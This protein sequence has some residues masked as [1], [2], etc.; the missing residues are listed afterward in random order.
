LFGY[1]AAEL[2]GRPVTIL[3]PE[4]H[5]ARYADSGAM[6]REAG[7]AV[8]QTV[9]LIGRRR[10]GSD[11]PLEI[12][13][14]SWQADGRVSFTGV[15]RDVS[16]RRRHADELRE[17]RER[18]A[19]AFDHA[20]IGMA[21]VAPD[22][23]WL[24]VNESLCGILGYSREEL[25]GRTFQDITHPDD[26]DADLE[27]VKSTL[28]GEREGYEMQKRYIHADGHAV[29]VQLN[30][31][32]VRNGGGGPLYFISQ[33]QD[34][35]DRK[36]SL[37]ELG[38]SERRF[39]ALTEGAPVGIFEADADGRRIYVND[40]WCELAGQ[41][42]SDA[43]GDGWQAAVHPDDRERVIRAWS[44]TART[45][46]EFSLEYRFQRP[47]GEE[48]WVS[49]RAVALRDP[50]GEVTGY[51][52]SVID[53][54]ERMR[55]ERRMVKLA[56]QD[57][58]T[59]LSN[60]PAFYDALQS[61]LR[62]STVAVLFVD[63]DDFKALND[64]LGHIA[65]D[66]LLVAVGQLLRRSVRTEDLV[67]RLGGDEFGVIIP[68]VADKG[69]PARIAERILA[70]CESP[71]DIGEREIRIGLSI[72]IAVSSGP[73]DGVEE[74]MRRA[75]TA[76]YTAKATGKGCYELAP[77]GAPGEPGPAPSAARGGTQAGR[78]R[79]DH[80][81]EE[82][83]TL[84]RK[85]GGIYPV[86]QP[87]VALKG[88]EVTGHEALSRFNHPIAQPPNAWFAQAHRFGL[89]NE[90]E[91]RAI[92]AA[93]A[94][95]GR[96]EGTFLSVNVSPTAL[97]STEIQAALPASL[98]GIVIEITEN[99]LIGDDVAEKDAIAE[100]RSRGALLAV[101]D[102]GSGYAGLKQ[103]L[104]LKPDLI[105]VDRELVDGVHRD[106]SKAALLEAFVSYASRLGAE[107]C[108]EGVE[109]LQDLDILAELGLAYAQ[110][111]GIA[112]PSPAWTTS[113]PDVEQRFHQRVLP[114]GPTRPQDFLA[115]VFT[116]VSAPG[117]GGRGGQA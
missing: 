11:V 30:V 32:L 38:D 94:V 18:F 95:P 93:L 57:D 83:E 36:R 51:L 35:T 108:A 21:L 103:L 96:P 62:E 80:Q 34:I 72:G 66:R 104:R 113:A 116:L 24:Q 90:L 111:F 45:G 102:A 70:G 46:E 53:I 39:R 105:K 43:L 106:L 69:E 6:A 14:A 4:R 75:D 31:S 99:E 107:V 54:T 20:A 91:A 71:V 76:M 50:E 117:G 10:D 88:G 2:V 65:G 42:A 112:R 73:E 84:L 98:E 82:I 48:I 26:L 85:P 79:A 37:E 19:G 89:G 29:W 5:R 47:N 1:P 9:E 115:E 114:N 59:G 87:L 61:A 40:R 68:D 67:A 110:G 97:A 15:A 22:G 12:S 44:R 33:V 52:G 60:R 77:G 109:D 81:R 27:L 101:D 23:R 3:M 86:F 28:A 64:R 92:S 25:L 58:L 7:R 41:N 13:I 8:G 74:V 55:A 49:G 16:V 63:V 56:L 78:R 100:A 17:A